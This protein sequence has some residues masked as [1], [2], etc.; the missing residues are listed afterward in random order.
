MRR[1]IRILDEAGFDGVLIPDHAPQMICAAP[2]HA[3]MA[4]SMGYIAALVQSVAARK[5]QEKE[6]I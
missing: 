1:V 5:S 4:F 6:A 3:G 2:W